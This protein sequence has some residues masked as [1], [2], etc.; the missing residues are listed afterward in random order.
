M[1]RAI[2][3]Y[4]NDYLQLFTSSGELIPEQTNIIIENEVGDRKIATVT[5]TLIADISQIG[6]DTDKDYIQSETIKELNHKVCALA[7]KAQE[8]EDKSFQSHKSAVFWE[9][10]YNTEKQRSWLDKIFGI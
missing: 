3:K 10:L 5:V 6:D 8:L 9:T 7:S 2:V 4:N 1:S